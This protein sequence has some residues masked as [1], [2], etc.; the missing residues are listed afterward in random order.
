MTAKDQETAEEGEIPSQ[1]E[2]QIEYRMDGGVQAWLQVLGSWILFANT[3]FVICS[4]LVV[5]LRRLIC[6]RQTNGKI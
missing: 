3:W 6:H 1:D 4:T 2:Q 5:N